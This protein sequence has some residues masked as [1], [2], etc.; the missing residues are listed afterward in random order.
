MNCAPNGTADQMATLVGWSADGAE[1]LYTEQ[2][3][4]EIKL[5]SMAVDKTGVRSSGCCTL[6]LPT[7]VGVVHVCELH[8]R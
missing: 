8:L 5:Y 2:K 4:V 6:L 1:I 7:S 3:S